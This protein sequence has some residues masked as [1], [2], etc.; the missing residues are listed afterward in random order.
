MHPTSSQWAAWSFIGL[1]IF[2]KHKS[3]QVWTSPRRVTRRWN[4]RL[5]ISG[6][7]INSTSSSSSWCGFPCRAHRERGLPKL[8]KHSALKCW[9]YWYDC[10][11][12]RNL[13]SAFPQNISTP[14]VF[15][16]M[17]MADKRRVSSLTALRV[18]N[19]A[20]LKQNLRNEVQMVRMNHKSPGLLAGV[21]VDTIPPVH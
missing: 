3:D 4:G 15:R 13:S 7:H 17:I 18:N 10:L 12:P 1:E 16:H 8:P 21:D 11:L 9:Y 19:V 14:I 6:S 2:Q 20:K 5:Q